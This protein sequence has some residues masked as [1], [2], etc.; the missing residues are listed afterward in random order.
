MIAPIRPPAAE[1]PVG[2]VQKL[3]VHL[4]VRMPRVLEVS[5]ERALVA[6]EFE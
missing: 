3:P 2:E 5:L 4:D 1:I 6:T